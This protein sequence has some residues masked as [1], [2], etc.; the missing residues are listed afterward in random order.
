VSDF[1]FGSKRKRAEEFLSQF[2]SVYCLLERRIGNNLGPYFMNGVRGVTRLLRTFRRDWQVHIMS[3]DA[4][5][6]R[7]AVASKRAYPG[8]G[9]LEQ[10]LT[11]HNDSKASRRVEK[12]RDVG[13]DPQDGTPEP[14]E[15]SG[16]VFF[17]KA[18]IGCMDKRMLTAAMVSSG[19]KVYTKEK[20][21]EG[22]AR[23]SRDLT[24]EEMRM[25]LSRSQESAIQNKSGSS[26]YEN[27]EIS[28]SNAVRL[29]LFALP[30]LSIDN[31]CL[32]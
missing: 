11:Q 6:A 17:S 3:P 24:V 20:G 19:L 13:A 23:R 29:M 5:A 30:C 28:S 26:R 7:Q 15:A 22:S 25:V 4:A 16:R 14:N 10:L 18:E 21:G 27:C 2:E 32:A 1:G 12:A 9:E 31:F 8:Y